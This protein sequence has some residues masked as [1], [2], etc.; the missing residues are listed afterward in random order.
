MITDY[1][2]WQF[3]LGPR[4]LLQ[5]LWNLEL[6]LLRYFSVGYMLRTLF[7][8]WHKDAVP[9]RGG[10]ISTY[11]ITFAWNQISRAIGFFIRT[12]VLMIWAIAQA[13]YGAIAIS[14][15]IL[16]LAWPYIAA[17]MLVAGIMKLAM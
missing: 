15:T 12:I 6:A 9:Y 13:V 5:T 2:Y 3:I 4:W 10:Y 11:L 17:V 7:A 1:L 14:L 16:F 8:H